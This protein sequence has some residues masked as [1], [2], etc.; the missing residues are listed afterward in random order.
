MRSLN[1]VA[2]LLCAVCFCLVGS[3]SYG[4]SNFDVLPLYPSSN[5]QALTPSQAPQNQVGSIG[6]LLQQMAPGSTGTPTLPPTTPQQ[7]I[8]QPVQQQYLPIIPQTSAF[9]RFV[10]GDTLV[11]TDTQLG[12]LEK[13]AGVSF[14]YSTANLG[15][16][17]AVPVKV[18]KEP[19]PSGQETTAPK[20]VDAGYLIGARETLEAAF[21]MLGIKS[22][23]PL[24]TELRQFGYDLFENVP[25]SFVPSE[26][27]PVGPNYVLGPGDEI[28]ISVWGKIQGQ[29]TVTVDRDGNI[30]LPKLGTLGVAGLTFKEMKDM[31]S[32]EMARYYTGFELNVSMGSL[33]TMR[34]YV[35]G[36]AARPGAYTVSSLSTLVSALFETGGP[37]KS[38]SMRNIELRRNGKTVATFD[39]YDFLI[40]GDKSK[41]Q[42]LLPEDVIFIPPIG[43]VAAIAG[44]VH[45]PAIYELKGEKTISQLIALAGGTN[46]L[47]FDGRVQIERIVN[48]TRQIVFESDIASIRK[49]K[50]PLMSGDIV[51]IFQIVEDKRTVRLAGAV[52]RDGEFGFSPGMTVKDLINKAGGLKYY[53]YRKQAEL[54]RVLV[55]EK[56][57]K[58][59]K[60]KVDLE[61]ALAGDEKSNI[62][63]QANDYLFIRAVPEWTLYRTVNLR[64]EVKFPGTYT[65]KK[66][67]RLASLLERAGGFTNK[68]YLK[69][70]VFL[71]NSVQVE[72]QKRLNE[73]IDRLQQEML[74]TAALQKQNVQASQN[75]LLAKLRSV[76]PMGRVTMRL[77]KNLV[78]FEKSPYNIQLEQ[79]DD[80]YIPERPSTVNVMG[81]LYNPTSFIYNPA[82]SVSGYI[83]MAGGMTDDA[84]S[85]A[86]FV[87]KADGSAVS[88]ENSSWAMSWNPETKRYESG[89]FMSMKLDPGD[90]IVVP[91]ELQKLAWL[92]PTKDIMQI[93]YQIAVTAGV[94][95]KT[96]F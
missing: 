49:K 29:W 23:Y 33:R 36:N 61:K 27:V 10:S 68:A 67:E 48:G 38:G 94:L 65:F 76:K 20:V 79:G 14:Q 26:N 31:L 2:V 16:N 71:R 95:F 63:L 59:E 51:K 18:V 55:T 52:Q 96:V 62:S 78:A 34:I 30:S 86:I 35:V 19:N 75:A 3:Y 5:N 85:D 72:Q 53:A 45:N 4:Q 28:R 17:I 54:T 64:G 69:G 41:D 46:A 82:E 6:Q 43:P 1:R 42:R 44:N 11:I 22:S 73:S 83:N 37:S 89:G 93:V 56:G 87:I 57:P 8:Q 12:I 92:G 7:N 50:M 90:T 80:I 58:T 91:P 13:F 74:S 25:A 9:E 81:S 39:L 66:G 32:R 60:I 70:A 77:N 40:K 84:N 21:T 15:G 47:A 88:R 24:A